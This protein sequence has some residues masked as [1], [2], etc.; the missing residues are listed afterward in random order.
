MVV[1]KIFDSEALKNISPQISFLRSFPVEIN[2]GDKVTLLWSTFTFV[3]QQI[4]SVW[5]MKS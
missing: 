3:S 2:T 1:M 5:D 4:V